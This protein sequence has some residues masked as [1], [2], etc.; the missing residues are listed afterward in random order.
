VTADQIRAL[1]ASIRESLGS[2]PGGAAPWPSDPEARLDFF[3]SRLDIGWL[4]VKHFADS[5]LLL[6]ASVGIP[7]LRR[8]NYHLLG[9]ADSRIAEAFS[10]HSSSQHMRRF[11]LNGLLC[12]RGVDVAEISRRLSLNA[13]AISDYAELYY[14]VRD[15]LEERPYLLRLL[16]PGSRIEQV[17]GVEENWKRLEITFPRVGYEYGPD[18]VMKLAGAL[19]LGAKVDVE[20]SLEK[21]G[22]EVVGNARMLVGMGDLNRRKSPGVRRAVRLAVARRKRRDQSKPQQL[23][24][25][26]QMAMK[27]PIYERFLAVMQ[28]DLERRLALMR[29]LE[30]EGPKKSGESAFKNWANGEMKDGPVAW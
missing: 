11:T 10:L 22:R 8:A 3:L 28:P 14:N 5:G 27:V 30:Q 17:R 23:D 7:V 29:G 25:I 24:A 16:F 18:A 21:F 4:V 20:A 19:Q 15:R 26:T 9:Y 13:Q 6:P 12:C 1:E 2:I